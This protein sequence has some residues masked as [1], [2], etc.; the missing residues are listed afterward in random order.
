MTFQTIRTLATEYVELSLAAYSAA[1]ARRMRAIREA[2]AV[3]EFYLKAFD[4]VRA[5]EMNRQIGFV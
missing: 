2:V 1:S 3:S 4:R 5:L